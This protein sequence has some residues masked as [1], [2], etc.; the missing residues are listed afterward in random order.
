MGKSAEIFL[1]RFKEAMTPH[2][3]VAEF[4]RKA[5]LSRTA[6][7]NWLKGGVPSIENIDKIADALGI[8]PAELISEHAHSEKDCLRV[9][10]DFLA[11]QSKKSQN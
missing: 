11:T 2:G 10:A 8:T 4:C 5:G 7:D 9:A 1:K 6:V 3:A